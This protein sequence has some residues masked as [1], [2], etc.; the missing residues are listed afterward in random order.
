MF[1]KLAVAAG[2][3]LTWGNNHS[4]VGIAIPTGSSANSF[5]SISV[6]EVQ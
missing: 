5:R 1:I 6:S 2:A 3:T 4:L